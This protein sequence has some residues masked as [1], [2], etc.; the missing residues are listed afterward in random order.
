LNLVQLPK[1]ACLH[2]SPSYYE[3]FNGTTE[4]GAGGVLRAWSDDVSRP[5]PT[6]SSPPA[7]YTLGLLFAVVLIGSIWV[8][9]CH[10]LSRLSLRGMAAQ[11]RVDRLARFSSSCLQRCLLL[12]YLVRAQFAC[13]CYAAPADACMRRPASG[14][15]RCA[16]CCAL[17]PAAP[18]THAA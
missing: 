11:E 16:R 8:F 1:T 9:G 3:Q 18:A 7:G 13:A 4:C 12:L 2:P 17:P 5:P 14:V 6:A 10:I 15:P